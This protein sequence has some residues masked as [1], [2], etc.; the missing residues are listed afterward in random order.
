MDFIKGQQ[1]EL[2]SLL[3]PLE[4]SVND[5]G[6]NSALAGNSQQGDKQRD[7]MYHLAQVKQLP[8]SFRMLLTA[9]KVY[10]FIILAKN[11]PMKISLQYRYFNNL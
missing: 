1:S 10:Y 6:N 8:K 7:N 2:E 3:G 9:L 11:I 5:L 4:S